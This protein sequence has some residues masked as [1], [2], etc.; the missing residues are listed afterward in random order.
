MLPRAAAS[1]RP[2]AADTTGHVPLTRPAALAQGL[3]QWLVP[4]HPAVTP[5]SQPLAGAPLPAAH[6]LELHVAAGPDAAFNTILLAH[7][8]NELLHVFAAEALLAV[9]AAA[10][11][12]PAA[13]GVGAQFAFA[14]AVLDRE[15]VL[16]C[17]DAAAQ[18]ALLTR[19][20]HTLGLVAPTATDGSSVRPSVRPSIRGRA[21]G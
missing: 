5:A 7:Q 12:R 11:A 14:H 6:L 9:A 8:R 15:V 2:D 21:G 3:P 10:A 20:A 18:E 19:T 16:P 13:Q 1:H 17:D 4:L